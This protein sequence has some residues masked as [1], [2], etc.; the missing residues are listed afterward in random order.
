ML[1]HSCILKLRYVCRIGYCIIVAPLASLVIE[2]QWSWYSRRRSYR[3]EG[4]RFDLQ[5]NYVVHIRVC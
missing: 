1:V 5:M 3:L 4:V 2:R